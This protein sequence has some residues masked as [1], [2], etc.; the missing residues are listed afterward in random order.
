MSPTFRH[1]QLVSAPPE[2]VV[3]F[4]HDVSNLLRVSPP[5][6]ELRILSTETRIRPGAVFPVQVRI[7]PFQRI[8]HTRILRVELD[9][10]FI[11]SIEGGP[12]ERWEHMHRFEPSGNGTCVLDEIVYTAGR[13]IGPLAGLALRILFVHRRRAI[14]KAL[15]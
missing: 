14:Q 8:L 15:S 2:R 13:W 9:G 4:F 1:K 11:D 5:F 3:A 6:P 12:F 7:G 10:T